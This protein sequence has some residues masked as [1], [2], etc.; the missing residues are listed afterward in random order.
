MY[1]EIGRDWG[2]SWPQQFDSLSQHALE[3]ISNA[4]QVIFGR[5]RQKEAL[6]RAQ[7]PGL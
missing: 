3:I 1:W 4:R 7:Y 2:T 6:L 5:I